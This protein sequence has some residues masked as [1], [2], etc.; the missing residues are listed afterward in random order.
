LDQHSFPT[1]G[2]LLHPFLHSGAPVG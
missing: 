1:W 2:L